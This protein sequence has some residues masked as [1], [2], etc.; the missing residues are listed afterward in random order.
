MSASREKKQRQGA[1][2]SEKAVQAQ[3]E[4]AARKRK[5]I[6][7]T[8][9]GVVA[10]A[11]VAALLIWNSGFFQARATAATLGDSKLTAAELSYYYY[12]TRNYY[13]TYGPY[14]G[15]TFDGTVPDDEQFADAANSVTWRDQF[16]E[17]ALTSAQQELALYNEA[18]AAGYTAADVKDSLDSTVTSVKSSAA[19][20]GYSYSAYLRAAYGPYMSA[21]VFEELTTRSLLAE[22]FQNDKTDEF[23]AGYTQDELRDYYGSEDHADTL[24]TFEYSYLYFT[25]AEVATKDANGNDLP[26]SMVKTKQEKALD[27]ARNNAAQALEEYNSGEEISHLIEHFSPSSSGDHVT[28][29]G[30]SA[31]STI[32]RDQLLELGADEAAV[33]EN[34]TSGYYLVVFH[35]RYLSEQPTRD[36]RHILVRAETTTDEDGHTVAPTDEAWAAAK[37]K[38]DAIQAEWESGAKTEDSFAALANEKSDDGNGTTGGLYERRS[39]GS[40]V[41]EFNDWVFDA[42]RQPGE[43]GI[44]RHEGDASADSQYNSQYWGYHLIYFV[45]DNE[46]TWMGTVRS[47]LAGEAE[48]E[49][50]HELS[51]QYEI[52]QAG[53]AD[54]IGK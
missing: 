53:G 26:E 25:P 40:F 29:V 28:T 54:Y 39:E 2:P 11:A 7:Y 46:P 12:G 17:E 47:T 24:D 1:G 4:Q 22:L 6:T 15:S 51:E 32:Y 44:V 3:Q 8:V 13:G 14:I 23:S 36:V 27:E 48:H 42:A 50:L 16:L 10:A 49:W 34:S 33:V 43:V 21:G 20:N 19:S 9:I 18:V 37:E 5:T 45:G 31:I 30:T 35:S 41:T 38:I 52:A